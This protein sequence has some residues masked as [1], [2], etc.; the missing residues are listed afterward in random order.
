MASIGTIDGVYLPTRQ[1]VRERFPVYQ[2]RVPATNKNVSAATSQLIS[3]ANEVVFVF[4][5]ISACG[6]GASGVRVCNTEI[7]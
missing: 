5:L 6:E 7:G 4:D 3:H 1:T 2:N